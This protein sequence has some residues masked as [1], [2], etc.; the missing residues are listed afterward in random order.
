MTEL[1]KQELEV[2]E[3]LFQHPGW[4]IVKKDFQG[5]LDNALKYPDQECLTNDQWQFRRGAITELRYFLNY[6][7]IMA[8]RLEE[9][10]QIL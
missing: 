5:L 6:D 3:N 1:E 10:A 8:S 9:D 4:K 2:L 7:V